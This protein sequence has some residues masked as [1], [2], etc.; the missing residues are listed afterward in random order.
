MVDL[1]LAGL[2]ALGVW[3]AWRLTAMYVE[4]SPIAGTSRLVLRL[5]PPGAVLLAGLGL[6]SVRSDVAPVAMAVLVAVIGILMVTRS[7]G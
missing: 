2:T 1:T 4:P 7:G 5:M 3:L 6:A